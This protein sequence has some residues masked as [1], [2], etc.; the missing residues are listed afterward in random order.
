[1]R[2]IISLL[3]A[4]AMCMGTIAFAS[5]YSD[6]D[7]NALYA[8][9]VDRLYDFGVMRGYEDGTFRPDRVVTRA[10]AAALMCAARNIHAEDIPDDIGDE[11]IILWNDG[12]VYDE[13]S[14]GYEKPLF[15]DVDK[16]HWAY[17]FICYAAKMHPTPVQ[18]YDD[19]TFRPGE[20]VTSAEFVKMC[21]CLIG[22]G[23]IAENNGGYPNG[24]IT[25]AAT[26]GLTEGIG[27]IA[28]NQ[29]ITR[30]DAAVILANTLEAPILAIG[31]VHMDENGVVS[32][33]PKMMDGTGEDYK[34][35]LMMYFD[36]Y[37]VTA[38]VVDSDAQTSR[39][40]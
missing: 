3:L 16:S 28:Y 1:M 25:Q 12:S 29:G 9:A 34:N 4:A 14:D 27:E 13:V 31:D 40:K 35:L 22:Y 11:T 24:Y 17:K 8:N 20:T 26:L 7:D 23:D 33:T 18:G 30:G 5:E 32:L 19:G 10:E 2:K 36:I 38:S 6:V 39:R 21:V 15:S 37:K